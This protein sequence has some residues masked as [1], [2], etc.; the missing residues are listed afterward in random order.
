MCAVLHKTG[1]PFIPHYS[2]NIIS[3][4]DGQCSESRQ[5]AC[6]FWC[7]NTRSRCHPPSAAWS[8][9]HPPNVS[10]GE[11][12]VSCHSA[13]THTHTWTPGFPCTG[14]KGPR[15]VG[16]QNATLINVDVSLDDVSLLLKNRGEIKRNEEM[17]LYLL[18]FGRS[19]LMN[20]SLSEH[21]HTSSSR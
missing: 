9:T 1:F 2:T 11:G 13:H 3:H 21:T 8:Y 5:S 20:M 7:A 18:R 6:R 12:S 15:S 16:C 4:R 17:H 10:E 14:V 19:A